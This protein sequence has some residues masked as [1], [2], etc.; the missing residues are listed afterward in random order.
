M[1]E[2][3]MHWMRDNKL[4]PQISDTEREALEAGD[5]W[6]DGELFGGNPD[7]KRMLAYSYQRL[8][9]EEQAFLD[10]PCEELLKRA[11]GYAIAESGE[12]PEELVAF[13]REKGFFGLIVPK[14]Y[15]GLGFSTLARS[16]IMAKVTPHSGTLSALVV[17]PNTLGAAEL[18]VDYGTEEQKAYY[19]PRLA[20]GEMIPC[21][22]LTEPG[23]GSD[24]ASI[25]AEGEVF[26]AEDGTPSIRLNFRKRYITLAPIADLI[27]LACHLHD[28]ENLLGKGE[29]PGI[30]VVL[31]HSDTPGLT[32]GERHEPIGEPFPNG[33]LE[34]K[35]VV[36]PAERILGG[37]DR[38]GQ[39]WKMLM[40]SLAGGRM[41][42]LPATAAGGLQAAAAMVG[43]YSIVREQ[44]GMPIGRMDG[45]EDKIGRVAA[46]AYMVEGARIFGCSA[47]NDGIHPPV[48]SGV[49]KAYTTELGRSAA[50][51]AMDVFAGAGVMQGP[52]NVIGRGY[53]SAPVAI[54]VEGANI[55]TRTLMIFGQ[56]ATRSHPYAI[57]VVRAV[58]N[59]DADAFRSNLLGWVGH[60]FSGIGRSVVRGLTRGWTVRVPDVHRDTKRYYRRLG[61]AA[62]RFGLLTDL[63]MFFVGGKLKARGKLTGRYADAVAWMLLGFAALRRFEAEG[64]R[65][66]DLPLVHHALQTALHEIQQAFEGIY[67]NFGG[68]VG[69]LLR[70]VG[71]P[72]AR[73]NPLGAAPD[74]TLSHAAAQ[75]IQSDNAQYARLM[76]G[77][78]LPQDRTVGGGRLLH[79]WR[80]VCA[81][82]PAAARVAAAQKARKLPRGH[83]EE[84][85]EQALAAGVISEVEAEQLRAA[86][87]ARM[88]AVEV[89]VFPADHFRSRA[90]PV[91]EPAKQAANF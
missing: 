49:M 68:P 84:L 79:A 41:V 40:E 60:F 83:A 5:V 87:A 85:A 17:I 86:R 7:F 81:A 10:G 27:S 48:V 82:Q 90:Q 6:L 13:M 53:C 8:T 78:F 14:E 35:D 88:A 32:Q 42:S 15:G 21:F 23:A 50:T 57:K 71:L 70:W 55:M 30:S 77:S 36:V 3:L 34:G 89:D 24:A 28:P 25:Q 22:G 59:D 65:E 62:A 19:L 26:R 2:K 39:G 63:A 44:F 54:T 74:D 80:Q 75:T 64:R 58:E 52:N 37:L 45:V 73:I 43:P 66:E 67:R 31:L 38:A 1:F 16:T 4:L 18:L 9:E 47:V 20:R 56:G 11:D 46:T 29:H 91:A 12:A 69:V 51:D 72:L 61:W 33:P 76:E